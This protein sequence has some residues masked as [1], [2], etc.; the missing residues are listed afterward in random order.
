MD[1]GTL[2]IFKKS[3]FELNSFCSSIL[4][5]YCKWVITKIHIWKIHKLFCNL[6]PQGVYN[7]HLDL[8]T[9]LWATD[10]CRRNIGAFTFSLLIAGRWHFSFFLH[11]WIICSLHNQRLPFRRPLCTPLLSY[12][13]TT[14]T[15]NQLTGSTSNWPISHCL[16]A[17]ISDG[18]IPV[19]AEILA[20]IAPQ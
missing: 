6:H 15:T 20:D 1:K 2:S 10:A 11:H 17:A 7:L 18:A 8:K 14:Q 9:C 12:D 13:V 4:C 5:D 16:Q 3:L 19:W